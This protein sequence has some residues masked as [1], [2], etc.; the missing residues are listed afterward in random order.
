MSSESLSGVALLACFLKNDLF[1]TSMAMNGKLSE[2]IKRRYTI[3]YREDH[4]SWGNIFVSKNVCV[5]FRRGKRLPRKVSV[6][7][8]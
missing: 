1:L 7:G 3:V 4:L 8:S 6:G 2:T 5:E